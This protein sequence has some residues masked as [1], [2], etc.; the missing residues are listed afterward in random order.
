MAPLLYANV[1]LFGIVVL[2]DPRAGTRR[3]RTRVTE[4]TADAQDQ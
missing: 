2:L 3:E 1:G 4:T